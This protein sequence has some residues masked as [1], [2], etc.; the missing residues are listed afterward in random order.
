MIIHKHISRI[1]KTEKDVALTQNFIQRQRSAH[2]LITSHRHPHTAPVA[3]TPSKAEYC[4]RITCIPEVTLQMF[5]IFMLICAFLRAMR[6]SALLLATCCGIQ[7][8]LCTWC[9][10]VL[11]LAVYWCADYL[12]DLSGSFPGRPTAQSASSNPGPGWCYG[13][14]ATVGPPEAMAAP[15]SLSREPN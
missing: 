14:L 12:Q 3:E 6:V 2:A 7:V 11:S 15:R 9:K 10:W 13:A 1:Q 8:P 4:Q 5:C